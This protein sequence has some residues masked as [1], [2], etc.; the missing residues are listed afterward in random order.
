[1]LYD[2][3]EQKKEGEREMM[4]LVEML[5]RMSIEQKKEIIFFLRSLQEDEYNQS[6]SVDFRMTGSKEVG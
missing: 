2:F 3:G 4:E 6:P 1:M 5:D